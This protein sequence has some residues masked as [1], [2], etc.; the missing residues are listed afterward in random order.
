M[1]LVSRMLLLFLIVVAL[2]IPIQAQDE[3]GEL[4]GTVYDFQSE[5]MEGAVV[6]IDVNG[7]IREITTGADGTYSTLLPPGTHAVTLVIQ[8]QPITSVDVEIAAGQDVEGNFDLGAMSDEDQERALAML[9]D[10]GDADSVREAFDLG[11]AALAEG[12]IDAAIEQF[13]IAAEGDDQHIILANLGMALSSGDRYEEAAR[14]FQLA[15]IQDP[16]NPVYHQNLGIALGNNGDIDGAIESITAAA[17]LDPLSAGPGFFNLGII[18]LNRGQMSEAVD[19]LNQSIE[20]DD[21]NAQAYYQLG[22]AHVGATPGEAVEPFERFLE[23][24]PDDPNAA[25]AQALLDF[26]RTQ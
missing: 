21:S 6:R 8:R 17:T 20:A 5:P 10:R 18:F 23:L 4:A 1:K 12:N 24:A 7:D 25:T 15:L 9:E 22:M 13:T 19:A 26:A 2:A 16:E 3:T 14:Q 11:R